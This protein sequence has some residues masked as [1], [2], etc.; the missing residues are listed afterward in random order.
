MPGPSNPDMAKLA[1]ALARLL[2]S[3]WRARNIGDEEAAA[4]ETAA[5]EVRGDGA[6]PSDRV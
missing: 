2:E 5:E 6:R 1:D 3:W 4:V